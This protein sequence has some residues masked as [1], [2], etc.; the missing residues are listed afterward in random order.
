VVDL[1]SL[2]LPDELT[3]RSNSSSGNSSNSSIGLASCSDY[4]HKRKLYTNTV[5]V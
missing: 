4:D 1:L 2:V 5:K 3:V